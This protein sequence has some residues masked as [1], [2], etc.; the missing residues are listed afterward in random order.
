M[1]AYEDRFA[2]LETAIALEPVDTTSVSLVGK[3]SRLRYYVGRNQGK[4]ARWNSWM[5]SVPV[6]RRGR[7]PMSR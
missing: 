7:T 2:R 4:G 6:A 5:S 1:G 3:E